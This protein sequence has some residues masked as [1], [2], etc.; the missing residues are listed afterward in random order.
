VIDEFTVNKKSE[1]FFEDRRSEF[2]AVLTPTLSLDEFKIFIDMLREK[3]KEM[4]HFCSAVRLRTTTLTEKASDDG[5]PSG[6][7]GRPILQSLQRKNL[8]NCGIVVYRKYG[9]TKLGTGGLVRAYGGSA[10]LAI[11]NAIIGRTLEL[12]GI[13]LS[14]DYSLWAKLE[15]DIR[16]FDANSQIEFSDRVDISLFVEPDKLENFEEI[17][18]EKTAGKIKLAKRQNKLKFKPEKRSE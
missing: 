17:I 12:K 2:T 13:F 5:E 9:G 11:E 18:R 10:R 8:M 7:A 16:E 6:T 14:V 4:C 15:M 3:H 1:G